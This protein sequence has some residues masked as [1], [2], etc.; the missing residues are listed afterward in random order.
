MLIGSLAVL[1]TLMPLIRK[2]DWWIR[3]F[4]FPR[5]QITFFTTIILAMYL[6]LW[7]NRQSWETIFV[8]ILALCVLYQAYRIYPYTLLSKKQVQ[9]SNKHSAETSISVLIVNVLMDNR[10][11]S[12]L[13]DIIHESDPDLI[14]ALEPDTWWQKQLKEFEKSHRHTVH[15]PLGNRYG[16]LLYSKLELIDPQIKFLIEDDI[17]SVHTLV[18][19]PSGDEI[20][21]HGLHPRPPSPT[22][23]DSSTERDAELL[24]VAKGVKDSKR[25]VIVAGDLNDVAWSLSTRLFQKISGLLDPRIGRGFFSTFNAKYPLLR[26]PL[27]HLFHSDDFKL[28]ELKRLPYFGSD[29]FPILISLSFEPGKATHQESPEADQAERKEAQEKIEKADTE[30]D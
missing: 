1:A 17:P 18:K 4:D 13:R 5:V 19:L 12:K 26:W 3:A 14:L 30:T 28:V 22:E 20:E 8:S 2:D 7:D 6:L 15:H 29:H 24:T 16:I 21:L 27:D 11:A 25:P 23:T 10:N 9:R